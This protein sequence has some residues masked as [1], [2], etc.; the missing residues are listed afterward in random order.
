MYGIICKVFDTLR[1]KQTILIHCSKLLTKTINATN[2]VIATQPQQKWE[3]QRNMAKSGSQQQRRRRRRPVPPENVSESNQRFFDYWLLIMEIFS[4]KSVRT[5]VH[6]Q[7]P[8]EAGG[9]PGAEL[10]RG[11]TARAPRTKC[12]PEAA[13]G[14]HILQGLRPGSAG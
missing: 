6:W 2:C 3:H 1:N 14:G 9:L 4:S 10:W 5:A 13:G 8:A 7:L 11:R 12:D